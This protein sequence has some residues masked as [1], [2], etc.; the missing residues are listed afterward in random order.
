MSQTK[1]TKVDDA[2]R[3]KFNHWQSGL[4]PDIEFKSSRGQWLD[5]S[6]TSCTVNQNHTGNTGFSYF[7][8][9]IAASMPESCEGQCHPNSTTHH[10]MQAAVKNR[11]SPR[12][13]VLIRTWT[14]TGAAARHGVLRRQQNKI[15]CYTRSSIGDFP[16]L[17][18]RL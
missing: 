6:C 15:D 2:G 7:A 12:Y 9:L 8:S 5:L 18:H 11:Q 4:V 16:M 10:L 13:R 3:I 14:A 17:T 1:H